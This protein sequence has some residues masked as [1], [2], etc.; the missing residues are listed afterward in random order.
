MDRIPVAGP[1]VTEAE[2]AEVAE[3]AR[4]GWYENAG[5]YVA[6]F[7]RDFAD[8]IGVKHAAAVPH[9]TSA[10]HL[11]MLALGF[12]PG[13]EVIVPDITWIASAAPLAQVGATPVFVDIDPETWVIDPASVEAAITERTRGII[14]VGLYGLT[15]DYDALRAIA[16]RH[17]LKI[18]EDAAQVIGSR[19]KGKL[20][21]NFGDISVFSFHGTK[22]IATG[23][24]GMLVTD[25]DDLFE[26]VSVLRDHGRTKENFKNFYNTELGYKY[27]M[28]SVTAALGAAQLARVEE[29]IGRKR[30]IFGWYRDRLGGMNGVT[31]NAEPA[32]RFNTYWMTTAVLDRDLGQD[33]QSLMAAFSERGIDTRPF[34]H[35]MSKLPAYA[36]T[37]S[38]QGAE[39][40]NPVAYDISPRGIN[41]PSAMRLTEADVDRV[42]TALREILGG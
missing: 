34:F 21:G 29:L 42:S 27:R 39:T 3:A 20:A 38:A 36:D 37:P 25:D 35:P 23:E 11:G 40:R 32:D 41:L 19:Y 16:E 7:E 24:G 1:W 15:P 6:R 30:E 14:P 13:D 17:G 12:G 9:C 2:V 5:H 31:L 4:S 33:T 26:R 28:N 10:L 8:Y 18:L 22:L